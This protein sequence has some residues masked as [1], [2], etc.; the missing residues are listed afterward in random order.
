MAPQK[1]K[2]HLEYGPLGDTF[3]PTGLKMS[4]W[5]LYCQH[6]QLLR[7][8]RKRQLKFESLAI[9][10][11]YRLLKLFQRW[12]QKTHSRKIVSGILCK[13]IKRWVMYRWRLKTKLL[14]LNQNVVEKYMKK[15]G[16][17][18]LKINVEKEKERLWILALLFRSFKWYRLYSLALKEKATEFYLK[19]EWK[20]GWYA[21]Y[22]NHLRWKMLKKCLIMK[23]KRAYAVLMI[24]YLRKWLNIALQMKRLALW[25]KTSFYRVLM[26]RKIRAAFGRLKLHMRLTSMPSKLNAMVYLLN[27]FFEYIQIKE[28]FQLLKDYRPLNIIIESNP[29]NL[30]DDQLN[31]PIPPS[32]DPNWCDCVFDVKLKSKRHSR[33][34]SIEKH[35]YRRLGLARDL[36]TTGLSP[37]NLAHGKEMNIGENYQEQHM[38][39][40]ENNLST[41]LG[42]DDNDENVLSNSVMTALQIN[43]RSHTL[44]IPSSVDHYTL[45]IP[46]PPRKYSQSQGMRSPPRSRS[47]LFSKVDESFFDGE[48]LP[49]HSQASWD[50]G[51]LTETP[52]TNNNPT[53]SVFTRDSGMKKTQYASN[54]MKSIQA[55]TSSHWR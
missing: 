24:F 48:C 26:R 6:L 27:K 13:A 38:L 36:V 16:F 23:E 31:I 49:S 40:S 21:F 19:S 18:R 8:Q 1:D 4:R 29:E 12:K 33:R 54:F 28:S 47:K 34:C 32:L 37:Q 11:G 51:N 3:D 52:H 22:L 53:A 7:R 10:L 44:N 39:G 5:I 42:R 20:K 15:V 9:A 17:Q 2:S 25:E 14:R 45:Q 30:K 43:A 46:S 55:R 50:K 35:L 41:L